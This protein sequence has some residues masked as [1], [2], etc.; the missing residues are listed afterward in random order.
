VELDVPAVLCWVCAVH[1]NMHACTHYG[2]GCWLLM[3]FCTARAL[4]LLALP[5][6]VAL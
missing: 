2:N 5:K 6:E 1:V 3:L 4:P